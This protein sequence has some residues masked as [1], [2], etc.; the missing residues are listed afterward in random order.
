MYCVGSALGIYLQY[1][2]RALDIEERI[3]GL[4]NF[5]RDCRDTPS[6][7]SDILPGNGYKTYLTPTG[8]NFLWLD[9]ITGLQDQNK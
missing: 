5:V 7:S 8:K 1:N 4:N 2:L 6:L 3:Q 9:N